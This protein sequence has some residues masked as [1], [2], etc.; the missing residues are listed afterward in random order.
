MCQNVSEFYKSILEID[1]S[2]Y[3]YQVIV[4][5]IIIYSLNPLNLRSVGLNAVHN[6]NCSQEQEKFRIYIFN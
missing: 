2:K 5:P 6:C 1:M 3:K 4:E